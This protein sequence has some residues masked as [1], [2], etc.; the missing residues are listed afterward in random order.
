[1]VDGEGKAGESHEGVAGK[2]HAPRETRHDISAFATT[3]IELLGAVFKAIEERCTGSAACHLGLI[4]LG[5]ILGIYRAY[6]GREYYRLAFL[7]GNFEITGHPEV[8][9]VWHAALKVF[10]IFD[11]IVPVGFVDPSG[12]AVKLHVESRIAFIETSADTVLYMLDVAVDCVVGDAEAV[13]LSESQERT[14]AQCRVGVGLHK[15]IADQ[16][17]VFMADKNFLLGEDHATHAI[18]H[19][20]HFLA[21]ELTDILVAGRAVY[22]ALI[23]VYTQIERR[24]VLNHSLV[25]ARKQHMR[26]VVHLLNGYHE[27]TMLF[28]G[29]T[30]HQ[31]GA[32]ICTRTVGAEHLF[33]ERLVQVDEQILI[34]FKITHF[35]FRIIITGIDV[36]MRKQLEK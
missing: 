5:E 36:F 29:I 3:D 19:A 10:H 34:K 1:M 17:S 25:E 15:S 23:A 24:T 33:G 28:A 13:Y 4:H 6:T 14:E 2:Y 22:A 8:L 9:A 7:D 21:V 27:Q 35:G 20:R 12:L 16:D 32:V 26:L 30:T 31:R 11:T 18:S